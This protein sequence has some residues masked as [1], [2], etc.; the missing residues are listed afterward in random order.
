LTIVDDYSRVVWIYLLIDKKE[1]P[2]TLKMFFSMVEHQF[3]KQVKNIRTDNKTEFAC[4]KNYFLENGIIYQISCMG[5]PQQK[6]T[7]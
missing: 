6:W 7:C 1:V 2:S 3:N 5:T 4:M